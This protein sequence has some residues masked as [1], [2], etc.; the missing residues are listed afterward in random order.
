MQRW[1]GWMQ[2]KMLWK[3]MEVQESHVANPSL[4]PSDSIQKGIRE[5]LIFMIFY[6]G[7]G[8]FGLILLFDPFLWSFSLIRFPLPR[9]QQRRRNESRKV[10][11]SDELLQGTGDPHLLLHGLPF[12]LLFMRAD[13]KV[14]HMLTLKRF[15]S[16]GRTV[17][18]ITSSANGRG[19]SAVPFLHDQ[20]LLTVFLALFSLH[21]RSN[22]LLFHSEGTKGEKE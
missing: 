15:Q 3:M 21:H 7:A 2:I 18:R 9:I 16:I 17:A 8:F 11:E 19:L 6:W 13:R 1:L 5:A 22:K 10:S 20:L 14:S 4:L 12:C